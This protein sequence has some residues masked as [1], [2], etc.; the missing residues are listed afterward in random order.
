MRGAEPQLE[1]AYA[2][3]QRLPVGNAIHAAL[4]ISQVA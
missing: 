4:R 2:L 3:L 1:G